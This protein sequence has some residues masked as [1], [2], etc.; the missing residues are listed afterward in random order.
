MPKR[1][2]ESRCFALGCHSGY[3]GAPKA[4]LFAAPTDD[5]LRKKWESNLRR[6]DKPLTE[7]SAVCERHFE[8]RFILR[9]YVHI[10]NGTEVRLPR[11][12]PSLAPGAVPT[13]LPDCASNL[14]VTPVSERSERKRAAAA[15]VPAAG[16]KPRKGAET[17]KN[18]ELGAECQLQLPLHEKQCGSAQNENGQF[19]ENEPFTFSSLQAVN[20]PSKLW[21]RLNC[22]IDSAIVFATTSVRKQERLE[23]LHEKVVCF[24]AHEDKVSAQVYFRGVLFQETTIHSLAAAKHLLTDIDR[25]VT[26]QGIMP[27]SD[28]RDL[29]HILTARLKSAT[30][31]FGGSTF[32]TKCQGKVSL[33]GKLSF[34]NTC[35]F[36]TLACQNF[37][38]VR[39]TCAL[40]FFFPGG[41]CADCKAVR[42]QILTRKSR[43]SNRGVALS[44]SRALSQRL[45]LAKQKALRLSNRTTS[46]KRQLDAMAAE[47]AMIRED[48]FL[49]KIASLPPKQREAVHHMFKASS[50]QSTKGMKYS[51][52]WVLECL[53]M[54][55]KSPKLYEHLRKECILTMPCKTT[56]RKYLK[57]Y[58]TGYGFSAKVLDVLSK[59]TAS[60]DLFQRHGGLIVDEMKLSEQLSVTT[61]GHIEGFVDLGPFTSEDDKHTVCDH[62]MVIMF[63][64]FVGKW[65]QVIAAF[66][67]KRNVTGAMLT[68]II[69][70]AVILVEKAGLK[71]DFIT[72]DGAAWNRKMWKI[73]GVGAS[74]TSTHCSAMHPVHPERQ[75]YFLSD[76][77]HLIKCL[78][79]GLLGSGYLLPDGRVSL[80]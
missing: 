49:K 52:E 59:K 10:I 4:S 28:L 51:N 63:V 42:K 69:L 30:V 80:S 8:P 56:L 72:S 73:L 46:L 20:I 35:Y 17:A 15:S 64:P 31:I 76:F 11:G 62:G 36:A 5:E 61:A 75:L 57:S 13:L 18:E 27:E 26:C 39:L 14:S 41:V 9:D 2:T 65:T 23:I 32:S 70:E 54:K 44:R 24:N 38:C 16:K 66:A 12:K 1:K 25:V 58:K 74:A 48:E 68:K 40:L 45:K 60:M 55:M 34:L 37:T 53:M 3:P 78:R 43:V 7:S 22:G 79:N 6:T 21:C 33:H 19:T 71:V 67:T 77:P 50:Y 29:S 47:N